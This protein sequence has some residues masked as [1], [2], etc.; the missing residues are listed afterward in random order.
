MRKKAIMAIS[1]G[2]NDP[3]TSVRN[4]DVLEAD[5]RSSH[6]DCQVYRVITNDAVVEL[7]QQEGNPVYAVREA[8]AR[9]V[10]DGVTHLYAQPSYLLNGVEYEELKEMIFSHKADFI[11][12]KCGA[13]LL[14]SHQDLE[15]AAKALIAEDYSDLAEDEAV[16]FVGH[17]SH[18]TSN[19]TYCA[20]D[21]VFKDLGYDN[22]HVATF[23]AFP[24]IDTVIKHLKKAGTKKV[25]VA[26]FMFVAGQAAMEGVC[27]DASNSMKSQLEA[28]GFIV[29]EHRK[30]L[31]EY[32]GIRKVFQDH[33][34]KCFE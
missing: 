32:A 9:M 25:H 21:Y 12:V 6:P 5:Y 13:P 16:V 8:M 30:C 4:I 29:T 18:H 2:T 33:L 3:D 10:L 15:A 23:N 34:E 14:T 22:A 28:A 11:E 7:M 24:K 1:F 19:A 31:G 26:P 17:G 20:L 27:G